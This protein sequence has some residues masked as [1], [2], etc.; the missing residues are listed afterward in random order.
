[1]RQSLYDEEAKEIMNVQNR[2]VNKA[3]RDSDQGDY[4]TVANTGQNKTDPNIDYDPNAANRQQMEDNMVIHDDNYVVNRGL[5]S[6]G[7]EPPKMK[8]KLKKKKK[9]NAAMAK[10]D[11]RTVWSAADANKDEDRPV[12]EVPQM[13]DE[14]APIQQ[15]PESEEILMMIQNLWEKK[16]LGCL[17]KL[18]KKLLSKLQKL[19]AE[20]PKHYSG[21]IGYLQMIYQ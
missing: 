1:V 7:Q 18:D 20:N 17:S 6:V 19:V 21:K 10:N 9:R 3:V 14:P 5:V 8:I 16:Q 15:D 4:D 13:E 11:T 2:F 12:S